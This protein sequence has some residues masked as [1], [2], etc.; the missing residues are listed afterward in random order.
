MAIAFGL[1]AQ[2]DTPLFS[3][4]IAGY[5]VSEVLADDLDGD[6]HQEIIIFT[7]SYLPSTITVRNET[8][9]EALWSVAMGTG[10][11]N[12]GLDG[13]A[14]IDDIDRDGFR[15][16]LVGAKRSDGP[17]G[18]FSGKAVVVSG[19]TGQTLRT[20][21]GTLPS[22]YM[23]EAVAALSDINNDSYKDY[24]VCAP[25]V[26]WAN[27]PTVPASCWAFSGQTGQILYQIPGSGADGLGSEVAVVGDVTGDGK[28]DFILGLPYWNTRTGR[29][30]LY[31]GSNGQ[32]ITS[33]Q[34]TAYSRFG[35]RIEYA[36]DT[37]LNGHPEVLIR[38]APDNQVV[39]YTVRTTGFTPVRSHPNTPATESGY[40]SELLA[41]DD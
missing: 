29:A 30:V 15:D 3:S 8:A 9:T 18:T 22:Q 13:A 17:S 20:H 4:S 23:G 19:R 39:L 7:S 40:G 10:N 35:E 11:D 41:V 33:V 28:D 24:L 37:D 5:R 14:I 38:K 25:G 34:G 16:I 12:L 32:P 2:A 21:Y 6:G 27:N 36:G 1:P 31:S 26:Y